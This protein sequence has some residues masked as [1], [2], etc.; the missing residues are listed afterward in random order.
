MR[1]LRATFSIVL[2]TSQINFP[3]PCHCCCHCPTMQLLCI[4]LLLF[5]I[6]T[7]AVAQLEG[8][9]VCT[10]PTSFVLSMH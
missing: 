9:E 10:K 4:C 3:S 8:W 1:T 7:A 6:A 5:C 2:R